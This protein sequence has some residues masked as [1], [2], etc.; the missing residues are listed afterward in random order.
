MW[1]RRCETWIQFSGKPPSFSRRVLR[2]SYLGRCAFGKSPRARGTPRVERTHGPRHLA[3]PKQNGGPAKDRHPFVLKPQVRRP[4]TSRA[5]CSGLLRVTP[6]GLSFQ[7]PSAVADERGLPTAMSLGSAWPLVRSYG[8][9][10]KRLVT[11]T[12]RAGTV[13]LGPPRVGCACCTR[14]RPPRAGPTL[15]A[16]EAP[17]DGPAWAQ[18]ESGKSARG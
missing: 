3:T 9:A 10:T 11:R 1:H 16:R 6:A 4:S 8:A 7:N 12:G 18:Y 14:A 15:R 5:R 17:S 2:P 13:R